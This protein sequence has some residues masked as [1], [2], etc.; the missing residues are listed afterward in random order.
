MVTHLGRGA[1]QGVSHAIAYC[2]NVSRS[3]SAIAEFLV[4]RISPN[5]PV[6]LFCHNDAVEAGDCNREVLRGVAG[7]KT[8]NPRHNKQ[9]RRT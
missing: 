4:R 8:G 5:N 9:L 1:F 2:T 6:Q 7:H 3:L